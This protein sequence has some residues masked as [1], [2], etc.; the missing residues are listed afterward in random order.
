ME[1]GAFPLAS[2]YKEQDISSIQIKYAH[3]IKGL[4]SLGLKLSGVLRVVRIS[5]LDL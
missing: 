1:D 2:Q 3:M 4:Q 5:L